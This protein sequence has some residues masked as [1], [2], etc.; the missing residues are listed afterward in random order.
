MTELILVIARLCEPSS[1]L[2]IAE[3]FYRKTALPDLLGVPVE[4][5]DDNRLYRALHSLGPPPIRF[6]PSAKGRASILRRPLRRRR[7]DGQ[8]VD[9]SHRGT[10]TEDVR[11]EMS[12]L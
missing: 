11:E 1:E 10:R 2:H 5:V 6:R 8:I 4:K 9:H 7:R 3:H 12:N